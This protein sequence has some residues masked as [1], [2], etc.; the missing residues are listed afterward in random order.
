MG[1]ALD[2]MEQARDGERRSGEE[3]GAPLSR[4]VREG[5]DIEVHSGIKSAGG[6]SSFP[7]CGEDWLCVV[8]ALCCPVRACFLFFSYLCIT[9]QGVMTGHMQCP[10]S[11]GIMSSSAS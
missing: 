2:M 10:R 1:S 9:G 6:N 8:D 11:I 3:G 7:A 5:I 4:S